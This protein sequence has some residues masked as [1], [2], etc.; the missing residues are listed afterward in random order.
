MLE[1]KKKEKKAFHF[2]VS[3]TIENLLQ[4][5]IDLDLKLC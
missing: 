1:K 2:F 3:P 5:I 4:K